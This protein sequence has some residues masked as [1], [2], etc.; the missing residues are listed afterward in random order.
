MLATR[1]SNF[2]WRPLLISDAYAVLAAHTLNDQAET[3]LFNL[4]RGSGIEGLG[5]MKPIRSFSFQVSQFQV[6]KDFGVTEKDPKSKIR[7]PNRTGSPLLNGP[8]RR[9]GKFCL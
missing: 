9:Y 4:I 5:G 1:V 3:F 6:R 2:S 8:A 7:N